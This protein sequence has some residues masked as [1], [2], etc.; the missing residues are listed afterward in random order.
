MKFYIDTSVFG[1]Y[2]DREF[3]ED[4]IKFFEYIFGQNATV[5]YSDITISELEKA[6]KKVI[7]LIQ[8]LQEENKRRLEYVSNNDEAKSLARRYILEGALT[9]KSA[10]DALH[11]A[12]ASIHNVSVLV[13][14]NFRHR[15]NFIRIQQYNAVNL[16]SGY[17]TIDIRSPKEILP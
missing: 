5:I 2:F 7:G 8:T 14:W 4:T 16:K 9:Q 17:K 13:S 10:E 15:V 3:S 6:P 12:L 11:I 1:G